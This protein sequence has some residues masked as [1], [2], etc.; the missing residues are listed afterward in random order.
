MCLKGHKFH[1]LDIELYEHQPCIKGS[2]VTSL[3]Y[4][5]HCNIQYISTVLIH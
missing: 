4:R 3:D 1:N 5:K 2:V